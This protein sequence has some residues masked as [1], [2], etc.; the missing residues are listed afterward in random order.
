MRDAI[1]LEWAGIPAICIVHKT[2]TVGARSIAKIAGHPEY[3]M[4]I[5]DY[6]FI[7]IAVWTDE[8]ARQIAKLIAPQVRD[9]LTRS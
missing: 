9:A 7:P 1:E 4:V 6:P 2:M 3:P 8:E 5:V